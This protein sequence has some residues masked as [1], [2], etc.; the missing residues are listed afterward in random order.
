MSRLLL[1]IS[2]FLSPLSV[3]G[4]LQVVAEQQQVQSGRE[5]F[6][7]RC[8]GCHGLNADGKGPAAPML[9][10]K[11]RNLIEGSFKFRSTPSGSLPTVADLMRVLNQGVIGSAMPPFQELPESEKLAL[12]AYIRSLRPEFREA[13]IEDQINISNPPKEIFA[14]KAGLLA[15]A[16]IGKVHYAKA[17]TAC[18][19]EQGKGDGPSAAELV[20]SYEQPIRPANLRLPYSKSGR[21]PQDVYR[22]I[23][24]GLDG[25]PM[26]GFESLFNEKQRWELV[27]YV[28]YLRGQEA[29][30]YSTEEKLK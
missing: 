15:A 27:A 30:I 4:I 24:T 13:K 21:S 25:S 7:N 9:N 2:V 29:G 19:G 1:F 5:S 14:T 17:C 28:Y 8:S 6:V 22:A 20:D 10:P 26:P 18:H 23:S 3:A 12:V 16:A 11:P